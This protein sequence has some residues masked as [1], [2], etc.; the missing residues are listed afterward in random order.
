MEDFLF[1]ERAPMREQVL[2]LIEVE[3]PSLLQRKKT[4]DRILL[5]IK[6]FVE[7]YLN[8]MST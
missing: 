8:G 1:A 7:T 2:E 4:G 3:K 6:S 5:R